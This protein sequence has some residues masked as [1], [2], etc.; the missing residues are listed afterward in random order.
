MNFKRLLLLFYLNSSI[1]IP[2]QLCVRSK[3]MSTQTFFKRNSF[4][5][6]MQL[7]WH[8][9]CF[10]WIVFK[11][12]KKLISK[13]FTLPEVISINKFID[14]L[15]CI[16][17]VFNSIKR[18]NNMIIVYI[19]STLLINNCCRDSIIFVIIHFIVACSLCWILRI[20]SLVILFLFHKFIGLTRLH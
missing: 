19:N 15:P 18:D 7:I 8:V 11:Y 2:P 16:H 9:L 5:L 1:P 10:I 12:L 6:L 4:N 14:S 13:Y 3:H 20:V 17:V